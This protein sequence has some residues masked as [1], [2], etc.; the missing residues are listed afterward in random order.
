V[1]IF[2]K[3]KVKLPRDWVRAPDRPAIFSALWDLCD[4]FDRTLSRGA[5]TTDTQQ[6][7]W[8][9]V[10]EAS[11]AYTAI[12]RKVVNSHGI[13]PIG[14]RNDYRSLNLH[15]EPAW[16]EGSA[17]GR[18][19]FAAYWGLPGDLLIAYDQAEF[20]NKKP[21]FPEIGPNYFT[22]S[23][24]PRDPDAPT[25]IGLLSLTPLIVD[26]LCVA[27]NFLI[28][29]PRGA[30]EQLAFKGTDVERAEV[31]QPSGTTLRFKADGEMSDWARAEFYSPTAPA[32]PLLNKAQIP[33]ATDSQSSAAPSPSPRSEPGSSTTDSALKPLRERQKDNFRA[34]IDEM[35]LWEAVQDLLEPEEIQWATGTG[36]LDE[37][38]AR[39][40]RFFLTDRRLIALP[41]LRNG[42]FD[43]SGRHPDFSLFF[44]QLGAFDPVGYVH[45][46]PKRLQFDTL[47]TPSGSLFDFMTFGLDLDMDGDAETAF[48]GTVIV[49]LRAH[50]GFRKAVN[51][52]SAR[53]AEGFAHPLLISQQDLKG[54]GRAT[55]TA[56]GPLYFD[57][58]ETH[59][60]ITIEREQVDGVREG[61]EPGELV[62]TFKPAIP[63]AAITVQVAPD[64]ASSWLALAPAS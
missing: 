32:V 40:V 42:K 9:T 43:Q 54:P 63:L 31:R 64:D 21:L 44:D 1:G 30:K 53:Q 15:Q 5:V 52:P 6:D 22:C 62:I 14:D 8:A 28:S 19:L 7:F 59:A 34:N 17:R 29:S 20:M 56:T 3:N 49:A 4:E 27:A 48:Q 41:T 55:V 35:V 36:T 50:G 26:D 61:T 11:L 51:D 25:K 16:I 45:E 58:I 10:R 24:V 33:L 2:R 18:D 39:T 13:E 23:L 60:W 57:A 47:Y 37:N 46:R 12:E 38:P